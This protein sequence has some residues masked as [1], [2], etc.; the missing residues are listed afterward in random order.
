MERQ[1]H[2]ESVQFADVQVLWGYG[3][4]RAVPHRRPPGQG[5]HPEVARHPPGVTS[6]DRLPPLRQRMVGFRGRLLQMT[7]ILVAP[8]VITGYLVVT[9]LLLALRE[10]FPRRPTASILRRDG[11]APLHSGVGNLRGAATAR[12]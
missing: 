11:Y 8:F 10:I 7:A 12:A 6:M 1:D 2:G 9:V 3:S 5:R 4:R